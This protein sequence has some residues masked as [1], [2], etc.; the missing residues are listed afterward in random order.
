ML[1]V[2]NIWEDE[3]DKYGFTLAENSFHY[4]IL[5]PSSTFW[6]SSWDQR[7]IEKPVKYTGSAVRHSRSQIDLL[8]DVKKFEGVDEWSTG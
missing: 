8:L 1:T 4:I 7:M 5:N 2:K 3:V 6:C